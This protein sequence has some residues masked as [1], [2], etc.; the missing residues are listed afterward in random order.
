MF[1][2]KNADMNELDELVIP[3]CLLEAAGLS[4]NCDLDIQC[5]PGAI[6]IGGI[7]PIAIVPPALMELFDDLGI[8]H[9]AI[10]KVLM[11]GEI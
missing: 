10:R 4:E 3:N 1:H 9:A 5:V 2:T 7:D 8:S 11:E 6:I